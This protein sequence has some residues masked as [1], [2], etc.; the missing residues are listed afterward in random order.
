MNRS[1]D[2]QGIVSDRDILITVITNI[3]GVLTLTSPRVVAEVTNSSDG[4]ITVLLGGIIASLCGWFIAK[5]ASSFPNQSFLT[6]TSYL[7]SK[8]VAIVMTLIFSLQFFMTTVFYVR[9]L[10]AL[11]HQYLFDH[12]PQEI[13]SLT[14]LFVVIYA[15]SGSQAGI[16]RLNVL[17]FPILVVG[18]F[19]VIFLPIGLID[20]EGFL[21]LFQTDFEGYLKGTYFSVVNMLGFAIVFFYIGLVKNPRNTPK[22][23]AY[24]V[25]VTM[26]FNLV[27]YLVCVGVFGNTTMRN[28]FF[29]TFDLSRTV[30]IP[31]GFFERFDAFLFLFWTIIFF[32]TAT[33]ALDVTV[34]TLRMVFRNF[35]KINAVIMLSPIIYFTSMVPKSYLDVVSFNRLLGHFT[36]KYFLLVTILL[37]IAFKI[38]GGNSSE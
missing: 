14:F 31:G 5:I 18:L 1:P 8:P 15:V 12:T 6:Y 13:I 25:L 21:P 9:E 7:L 30:E 17:F 11:S 38:K 10:A 20:W 33:M 26:G 19:L 24:G 34:M 16:F 2:Y 3:I 29:P 35:K 23:T 37:G 36:I 28:M 4:W 22:M 27:I 32:T